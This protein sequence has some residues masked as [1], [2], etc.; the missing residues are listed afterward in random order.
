MSVYSCPGA[1]PDDFQ[2]ITTLPRFRCTNPPINLTSVTARPLH[3]VLL[4]SR[5]AGERLLEAMAAALDGTG[6]AILPLD[7]ALPR[8][9]INELLAAFAPSSVEAFDSSQQ[10]RRAGR[11]QRASAAG[12]LPGVADDV[13]VVLATSGSTGTPK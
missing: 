1:G 2:S 12:G 5:Q 7:P 3:A 10:V 4:P 11:G 6:P 8:A 13:A 9:R